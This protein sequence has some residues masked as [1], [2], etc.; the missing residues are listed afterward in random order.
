MSPQ[1]NMYT[2]RIRLNVLMLLMASLIVFGTVVRSEALELPPNLPE[3]V[4]YY[5]NDGHGHLTKG[6]RSFYVT[7][8]PTSGPHDP[9]W[10]PPSV[11][12]AEE[13]RPELLVHNLEHGNIVIYFN[14][15]SLKKADI[16]WLTKLTKRY[17]GQW[18][19]MLMVTRDD[20]KHPIV[21]S[22][23]RANL[24]LDGLDRERVL[25]FVDFFR[26]RGPEN[27]VR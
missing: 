2:K 4:E 19:G 20:K 7:D 21:L 27:A 1:E 11:Y 16:T 13:T 18:D 5:E 9:S 6:K 25:G 15:A 8:P 14:P 24:R 3:G 22:A 26:G 23:W 17:L 10:L 12:K